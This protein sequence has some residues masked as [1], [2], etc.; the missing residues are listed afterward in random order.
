VSWADEFLLRLATG[1]GNAYR[2]GGSAAAEPT[3]LAALALI[4]WG[5]SADA[6]AKLRWLAELQA[7]DG[8]LGSSAGQ[9]SPAWPT[10]L[11][12]LSWMAGNTDCGYSKTELPWRLPWSRNLRAAVQW[13]LKNQGEK[14]PSR[15]EGHDTELFGW[16][17]V[18]GTHSWVEP[19]AL[20]VLALKAAGYGSHPRTR[21]AVRL[22]IDRLLPDGGCNY[23]NTVV[24][25]QQ[26]V[27][28]V[29]PTG[30][31]LMALAGER[32]DSGR[33]GRSMRYLRRTVR[34]DT[35]PASLAYGLL[36]LAA[37]GET[38]AAADAWLAAAAGGAKKHRSPLELALLLLAAKRPSGWGLRCGAK[39]G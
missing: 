21:E 34:G 28:H 20:A 25:G 26:L 16:P 30:L 39:E 7:P 13:L 9:P 36:G 1:G 11:A 24:L 38:I 10:P 6:Q 19:T 18:L 32:D 31:A 15:G 14:V 27:P 12:V 23:G 8:S 17:W 3:A 37:Q 35:A 33:I 29:Q 2:E 22:L 5:R 4:A